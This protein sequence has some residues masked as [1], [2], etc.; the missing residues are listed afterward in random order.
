MS[1]L[2]ALQTRI[3]AS[4]DQKIRDSI[5]DSPMPSSADPRVDALE[6]QVQRLTHD[7]QHYQQQQSTHNHAVANQIKAID[8]K[9]DQHGQSR[10]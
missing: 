7:F 10:A 1:Q 3:E 8:T 4:V 6:Q 2:T 5:G 9:V